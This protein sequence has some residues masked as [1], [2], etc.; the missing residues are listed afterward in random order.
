MKLL[1][2]LHN[3]PHEQFLLSHLK[4]INGNVKTAIVMH[5]LQTGYEEASKK[6]ENH[7]GF[8]R[9]VLRG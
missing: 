4:R 5:K 8:V 2:S 6:L 7:N 3:P 1:L 9:K